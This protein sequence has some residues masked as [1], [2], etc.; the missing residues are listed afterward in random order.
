VPIA[1]R[2]GSTPKPPTGVDLMET[3]RFDGGAA[4][5]RGQYLPFAQ[6]TI[7]LTD[8]GVTRSDVVYD[9]VHVYRGGFFRLSD[10]LDRF[11]HSM[12]AR[13]LRPPEDRLA[14]EAILHRCVGLS[15]LNDAYVAMVALRGRPH[16]ASSRRF[17]DCENHFVAYAV[18]WIDAIP[19][20]V[21]ARGA[22]LWIGSRPRVPDASADPK[23]KTYQW[24]DFTSGLFEASDHGFDS[25]VLCDAEGF[26]TEG[27]GFN[28]FI[29]KDGKVM[30]PDRGS[31]QGITR[32]SVLEL[33]EAM[34]IDAAVAPIPRS[35][36]DEADE[37]FVTST[38][39]GIMPVTRIS[40]RILS[41]DRPGAIS[42]RLKQAYWQQHEESQ[43]RTLVRPLELG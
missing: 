19:S 1:S 23:V 24:S 11:T 9:V 30:T 3:N 5:V 16:V 29:V 13:R 8:W 14:I 12:A 40:G 27:P 33:C 6:A 22:H 36:L 25:T 21:Q 38:A 41:N 34:G 28:L 32:M 37:A 2:S 42:L 26:A 7:P 43:H 39:G 35:L 10:H 17:E 18:P 4:Y 15:G 20:D 31:L